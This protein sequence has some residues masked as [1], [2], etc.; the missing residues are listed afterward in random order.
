MFV[1]AQKADGNVR[2]TELQFAE[3]LLGR[4]RNKM[5]RKIGCFCLAG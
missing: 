4:R 5:N 2:E 3:P 1:G